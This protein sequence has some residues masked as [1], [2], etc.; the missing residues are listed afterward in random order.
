[1][2]VKITPEIEEKLKLRKAE[3]RMRR[4][5]KPTLYRCKHCLYHTYQYEKPEVC[6]LCKKTS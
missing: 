3:Y 4:G 5:K 2:A 6:P 1:M